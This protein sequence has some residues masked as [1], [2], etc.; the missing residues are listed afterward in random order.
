MTG[1][2][3]C[4]AA[5]IQ[6][7]SLLL[8]V[9]LAKAFMTYVVI[10]S[11][12]IKLCKLGR[13]D[14]H[15]RHNDLSS[16]CQ[17]TRLLLVTFIKILDHSL[18]NPHTVFLLNPGEVYGGRYQ[19]DTASRVYQHQPSEGTFGGQRDFSGVYEIQEPS[20]GGGDQS[21][22]YWS[23]S[24]PYYGSS[25]SYTQESD[26]YYGSSESYIQESDPYGV[27]GS[28]YATGQINDYDG[29][30]SGVQSYS[31]QS[32]ASW[33]D[34]QAPWQATPPYRTSGSSRALETPF[35]TKDLSVMQPYYANINTL[36][37]PQLKSEVP[38]SRVTSYQTDFTAQGDQ[39]EVLRRLH[40]L[41][42]FDK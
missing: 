24:D 17:K 31:D 34:L 10:S 32:E 3:L 35:R 20:Y 1:K 13:F 5:V 40:Q 27:G 9:S 23:Q 8:G 14:H 42:R 33:G 25:E 39:T 30:L 11:G 18:F 41:Y 22:N 6:T 26:P 19:E 2:S 29:G 16:N 7:V 12:V 37:G 38:D 28:P 21:D 15:H 36:P 4:S